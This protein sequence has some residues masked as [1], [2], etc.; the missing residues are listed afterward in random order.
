MNTYHK[1]YLQVIIS[2]CLTLAENGHDIATHI[3]DD[4][5]YEGIYCRYNSEVDYATALMRMSDDHIRNFVNDI[6]ELLED[7][8]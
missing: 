2:D 4:A 1:E 3:N 5:A 6:E 8:A 7:D